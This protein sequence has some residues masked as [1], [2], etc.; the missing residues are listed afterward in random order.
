MD[1]WTR[2]ASRRRMCA[3]L[4][5]VLLALTAV[6]CGGGST[7]KGQDEPQITGDVENAEPVLGLPDLTGQTIVINTWGGDIA[8]ATVTSLAEPFEAATGA[9]RSSG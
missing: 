5:A 2:R 3:S 7:S 9:K 6:A 4:S 8:D 1:R